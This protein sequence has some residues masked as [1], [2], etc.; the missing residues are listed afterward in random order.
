VQGFNARTI[1]AMEAGIRVFVNSRIDSF[2][3]ERQCDLITDLAIP[4]PL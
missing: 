2:I 3:D 1:A 4:L